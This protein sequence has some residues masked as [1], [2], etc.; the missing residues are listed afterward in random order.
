MIVLVNLKGDVY[1]K[2]S[3]S[4]VSV[5]DVVCEE[6][7][8]STQGNSHRG[9]EFVR[10]FAREVIEQYAKSKQMQNSED[11]GNVRHN[12]KGAEGHNKC[13]G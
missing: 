12:D 5:A 1:S 13:C 4:Q 11:D 6:E 7:E 2:I 9:G 10:E 3:Q 8:Q